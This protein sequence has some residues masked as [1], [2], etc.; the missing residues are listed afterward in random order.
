MTIA[1]QKADAGFEFMQKMG[2]EYFC[3][4][5]TDLIGDLNDIDDYEGRMKEIVAYLKAKM[6]ET[7]IKNTLGHS[8]RVWQR[9]LHER[10]C[11]Q[12]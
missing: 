4:H 10:R 12:P 2:I 3:F 1:K 9:P 8:K 7:G 5:D 11:N 6:D